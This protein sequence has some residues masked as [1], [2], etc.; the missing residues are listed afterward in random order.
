M[1]RK[2]QLNSLYGSLGNQY[3]R[4]YKL[5]NAKAITFSGQTTIKWIESRLNSYLNK[6]VGTKNQDFIIALDTD[7]VV[8]DSVISVN[9]KSIK[10]EDFYNSI[11]NNYLKYDEFNSDFVKSVSNKTTVSLSKFGELEEKNIKYVMKHKVKKKLYKIK[12]GN[13]EVIVTEDHSIIIKEKSTNIIKSVTPKGLSPEKHFIINIIGID[14]D[15]N[16][17]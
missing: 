15:T 13:D 1:A 9:G 16:A 5:E 4:Y 17:C 14:T 7:S 8:G 11:E 12:V 10:I 2:V 3:F 6:I